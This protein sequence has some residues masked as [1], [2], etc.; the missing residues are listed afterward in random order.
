[1][2]NKRR[3]KKLNSL[4]KTVDISHRLWTGSNRHWFFIYNRC[5]NSQFLPA[6]LFVC[7]SAPGFSV[8]WGIV[9]CLIFFLFVFNLSNI[10]RVCSK[11][12]VVI[13]FVLISSIYRRKHCCDLV[14]WKNHILVMRIFYPLDW[15]LWN[16]A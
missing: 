5:H 4:N 9:D 15:F 8:F 13:F 14:A 7:A 12:D 10:T 16:L 6:S 2:G 11:C 3:E 1:M